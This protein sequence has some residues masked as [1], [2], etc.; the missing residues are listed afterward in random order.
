MEVKLSFPWA[1]FKISR[2]IYLIQ[3][4]HF[5]SNK[6]KGFQFYEYE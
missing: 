6:K 3:L 2:Y 4:M 5:V 1:P